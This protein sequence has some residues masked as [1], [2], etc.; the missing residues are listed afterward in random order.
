MQI[1][2]LITE[3]L[4]SGSDHFGM[5]QSF[6]QQAMRAFKEIPFLGA[7]VLVLIVNLALASSNPFKAVDPEKLPSIHGWAYWATKD[8]LTRQ[9]KPNVVVFGSSAVMQP[10]W[11][12]EAAYRGSDVDLVSDHQS[13]YLGHVIQKYSPATSP[14]C[15]NFALPGAMPSDEYMIIQTMIKSNRQPKII[16]MGLHPRDL[17]DN[18]FNCAASSKH[19]QYL[20]RYNPDLATSLLNLSMPQLWRRLAY[21]VESLLFLRQKKSEVQLVVSE[22]IESAEHPWLS[23][24][25]ESPLSATDL[26]DKKLAIYVDEIEKGVWIAHPTSP[27]Q[28]VDATFDC[29]RR[30]KKTNNE[31]FVNQKAW[32]EMSLAACRKA[33]IGVVLVNM[34]RTEILSRVM[35]PGTYERHVQLIKSLAESY[36][37][38][39]LD[40]DVSGRYRLDDYTDWIHMNAGGG[41]KVLDAI[42]EF[43]GKDN[44][45]AALISPDNTAL[46]TK[47]RAHAL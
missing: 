24:L 25:P 32:L 2:G 8:L 35:P 36:G 15:F 29:V 14:N 16:V 1:L 46:A 30:F 3:N 5:N 42:G 23:C 33:G 19:Y 21:Q 43:I 18:S 12:Q 26:K 13:R 22:E 10:L 34:P 7:I 20:S 4:A 17:M 39:Y 6:F 41:R 38:A 11:W 9:D 31:L 28:Y 45:L 44:A 27:Y 47:E 40:I 37:D